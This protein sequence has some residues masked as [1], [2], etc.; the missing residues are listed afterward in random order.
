M[1]SAPLLL[2]DKAPPVFVSRNR[3]VSLPFW[4]SWMTALLLFCAIS[5]TPSE[6]ATIPSALLP[7]TVQSIF[8][9][10]PGAITPRI[11]LME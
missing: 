8:Q 2:M 4:S 9:R 11:A 3:T 7:S 6:V 1:N 5:N 10:A